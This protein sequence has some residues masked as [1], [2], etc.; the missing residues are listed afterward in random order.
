MSNPYTYE[1]FNGGLPSIG[2][3]E[4]YR[5]FFRNE[6]LA[7][8]ISK[9][10][11]RKVLELGCGRGYILRYLQSLGVDAVGIDTSKYCIAT[12]ASDRISEI[13]VR[14]TPWP[15]K[16]KEFDFC[17]SVDLIDQLTDAEIV[18]VCAE[19]AR[20]SY[21]IGHAVSSKGSMNGYT[22]PTSSVGRTPEHFAKVSSCQVVDT[23]KIDGLPIISAYDR[24]VGKLNLCSGDAMFRAG[25]YNV[26][27]ADLRSTAQSEGYQF[28]M[29]SVVD[30]KIGEPE[31]VTA[32]AILNAIES[33]TYDE[34][35]KLMAQ[36]WSCLMVGGLIRV[37]AQCP[38][39]VAALEASGAIAN[40]LPATMRK[41]PLWKK[42]AFLA[43]GSASS[44]TREKLREVLEGAMFCSVVEHGPF[45]SQSDMVL[46]E[47]FETMPE[48]TFTLEAR[49]LTLC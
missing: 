16:D 26:D 9:F 1:Y 47:T 28:I 18:K 49:K 27:I 10:K 11:P 30:T 12:R 13:D 8:D 6:A 19:A 42:R 36:C 25:W 23:G 14:D 15:F 29:D 5:N 17:F 41:D 37:T 38:D 33:M 48:T 24:G 7:Y 40:I 4:N 35:A 31:T 3:Y 39:R 44:W 43:G 20:V 32:I 21:G 46:R 22:P 45:S 2:G 34:V